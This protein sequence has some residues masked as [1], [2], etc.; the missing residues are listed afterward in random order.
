MT[1]LLQAGTLSRDDF[2]TV[3]GRRA[4]TGTTRMN[5]QTAK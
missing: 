2:D 5:A 1:W 4:V 3:D